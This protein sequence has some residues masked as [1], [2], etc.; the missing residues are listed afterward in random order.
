M[1]PTSLRW[2]DV[3]WLNSNSTAIWYVDACTCTCIIHVYMDM[4]I[5]MY[6]VCIT[7]IYGYV[8]IIHVHVHVYIV[9]SSGYREVEAKNRFLLVNN[10]ECVSALET[11]SG[12]LTLK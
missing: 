11:V 4:Y 8:C 3:C 7:C 5:Y 9:V 10:L 2:M 12:E 1:D 6:I